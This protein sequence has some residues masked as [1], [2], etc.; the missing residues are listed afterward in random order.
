MVLCFDKF[1]NSTLFPH[2]VTD[3][4]FSV[5]DFVIMFGISK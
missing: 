1:Y 4:N 2:F 3:V 5:L